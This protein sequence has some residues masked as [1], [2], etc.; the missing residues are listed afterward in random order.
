MKQR[1][2]GGKLRG[3]GR[4]K[5][6][7][8]REEKGSRT[9]KTLNPRGRCKLTDLFTALES[10]LVLR[11]VLK[12]VKRSAIGRAQRNALSLSLF[13]FLKILVVF[14]VYPV[15]QHF[16]GPPKSSEFRREV[17]SVLQLRGLSNGGFKPR[18][19]LL[20]SCDRYN[21][22]QRARA[23]HRGRIAS[24][25]GKRVS[26]RPTVSSLLSPL[27]RFVVLSTLFETSIET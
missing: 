27:H 8:R 24:D 5:K 17:S 13:L 23:P 12:G 6:E 25:T 26:P 1:E 19:I 11:S 4:G 22:A 10:L 21:S 16:A 20:Q 2:R 3:P 14:T 9:R 18:P 15:S 7:R